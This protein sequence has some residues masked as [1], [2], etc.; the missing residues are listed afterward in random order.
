MIKLFS[1][2]RLLTLVALVMLTNF[3]ASASLSFSWTD[4]DKKELEISEAEAKAAG[5]VEAAADA[6][7]KVAAATTFAQKYAKSTLRPKIAEHVG[8]HITHVK[9]PGQR[10]K[11]A[12][13]LQKLFSEPGEVDV[14]RRVVIDAYASSDRLD[15][16]FALTAT[17]LTASPED[18]WLLARMASA[19]TEAAKRQNRKFVTNALQYGTKAIE[20]IEANKKPA[21]LDDATWTSQKGMLPRLYQDMGILSF[22]NKDLTAAMARFQK[23]V[24]LEPR[25]PMNY[26]MIATIF[27]EE[28]QQS[29]QA[30]QQMAAGSQKDEL[31]KKINEQLDQA[32]DWY[33]RAIGVATGRPEFQ[34]LLNQALQNVTPYYKYRHNNSTEGLQALID[35][36]KPA[37]QP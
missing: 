32:I 10:V 11:L 24:T 1:S 8:A 37:A 16:A 35:K 26:A 36:Y 6:A 13:E 27:D 18:V 22:V 19:G 31:L 14:V 9:D 21:N 25:D 17:A 15:E 2:A 29:A 23:A 5:E 3:S 30:Y 4:Q 7:A 28:Y 34:P 33:A 12:E 20:L